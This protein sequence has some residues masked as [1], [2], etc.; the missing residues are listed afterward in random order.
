MV[1]QGTLLY[2]DSS[3][4]VKLV[5][6]EPETN[7]LFEYLGSWPHIISSEIARVEVQRA[8]RRISREP[9]LMERAEQVLESIHLV[10]ITPEVLSKASLLGPSSL[11]TLDAIHVATA[12]DLGE[13]LA[14]FVAYDEALL[15]AAGSKRLRIQTPT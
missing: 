15:R 4:L 9:S 2:L 7:A 5:L 11:R 8:V 1:G 14:G 12:L 6:R 3:A 10:K 13:D